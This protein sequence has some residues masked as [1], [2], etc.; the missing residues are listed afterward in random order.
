MAQT[1]HPETSTPSLDLA[2]PVAP[3]WHT[4]LI[5]VIMA[6]VATLSAIS[7]KPATRVS[8]LVTYGSTILW[9]WLLFGL[10]YFGIRRAK[11]RIGDL[12]GT[13]WRGFDDALMDLIY[14]GALLVTSFVLRG[15]ILLAA[16]TLQ[17]SGATATPAERLK[18]LEFIAPHTLTEV[19]VFVALCFTAGFVEEFVFRGYMQRQMIALTRSVPLGIVVTALAFGVAH[20]YQGVFMVANIVVMGLLLGA[21]A[22]WRRS[23][24]PGIIAHTA[25]DLLAGLILF[26]AGRGLLPV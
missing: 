9:Q 21:L 19:L 12:L 26:M 11:L 8:P 25:Q 10:V 1:T 7:Q 14:G 3:Y 13:R 16:R 5:L 20:A 2:Q 18:A 17:L 23:L 22:Q 6:A 4:A 15:I 24:K